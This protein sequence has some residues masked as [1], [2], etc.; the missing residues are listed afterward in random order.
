LDQGCQYTSHKVRDKL[1][2]L[3]M[4]Q[5]MSRKGECWDNAPMERFFGSLKSEWI[6]S[7]G[8][9]T[10]AEAR[11]DVTNY[12]MYYNRTSLHSYNG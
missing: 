2:A 5:S 7:E 9:A 8:Y 12:L 4:G 11:A 3:E 10:E 6:P 1:T